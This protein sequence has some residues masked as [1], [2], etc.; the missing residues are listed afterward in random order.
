[1]LWPDSKHKLFCHAGEWPPGNQR[2]RKKITCFVLKQQMGECVDFTT[3]SSKVVLFFFPNSY[4]PA[5]M[6]RMLQAQGNAAATPP[7]LTPN[8]CFRK[9]NYE[10][11]EGMRSVRADMHGGRRR[12]PTRIFHKKPTLVNV[13]EHRENRYPPS[14]K[15]LSEDRTH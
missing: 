12:E 5:F 8:F 13:K 7:F 14:E 2:R 1:M 3:K 10:V 9:C 11:H 6:G 4:F 15:T